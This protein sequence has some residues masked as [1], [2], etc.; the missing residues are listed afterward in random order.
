M[1]EKELYQSAIQASSNGD[2]EKAIEILTNI[3]STYPD[4]KEAENA[5]ALRYNLKEG[6]N[7][8]ATSSASSTEISLTNTNRECS[9]FCVR[10]I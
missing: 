8:G 5:K 4:S 3:I 1:N 9:K 10:L 6:G 7:L 2:K